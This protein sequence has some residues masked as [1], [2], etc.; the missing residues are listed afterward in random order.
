MVSREL[1]IA[2][3]A[4]RNDCA[5]VLEEKSFP[6]SLALLELAEIT[7]AVGGIDGPGDAARHTVLNLTFDEARHRTFTI[8]NCLSVS[9][10][11]LRISE[12]TTKSV[13]SGP[14]CFAVFGR[15]DVKRLPVCLFRKLLLVESS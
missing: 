10:P 8:V 4:F 9:V 6:I 15:I 13:E 12:D 3:D 7:G 5:V 2:P 11:R 14:D 1:I